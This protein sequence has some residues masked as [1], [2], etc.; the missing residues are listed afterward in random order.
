MAQ[1]PIGGKKRK[2]GPDIRRV[3]EGVIGED[4]FATQRAGSHIWIARTDKDSTDSENATTWTTRS[5]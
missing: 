5:D 2:Q 1:R 4:A 3:G